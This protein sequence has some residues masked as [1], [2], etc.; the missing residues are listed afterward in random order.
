MKSWSLFPAYLVRLAGFA[1]ER[2]E[3]LRCARAAAAEEALEGAAAARAAAGRGLDEALGQERYA[4]NPAFDDPAARKVLSRHVK[5]ARAFARGL[6]DAPPPD[7]A[8]REVARVVPR[9]APLAH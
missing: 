1:F 7:E 4:G 9:A 5:Q 3:V 8:L 2:L 6:A